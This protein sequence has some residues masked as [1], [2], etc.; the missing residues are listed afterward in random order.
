M[1]VSK[2]S[3]IAPKLCA[4]KGQR[5]HMVKKYAEKVTASSSGYNKENTNFKQ[6]QNNEFNLNNHIS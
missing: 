4:Y 2:M 1:A 6:I 3:G 5:K